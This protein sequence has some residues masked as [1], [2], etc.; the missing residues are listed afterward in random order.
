M[1]AMEAMNYGYNGYASGMEQTIYYAYMAEENYDEQNYEETGET[2]RVSIHVT[3]N[4][5]PIEDQ[6]N[7]LASSVA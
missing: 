1:A 4:F 7:I 6:S 5:L 3:D 2:N